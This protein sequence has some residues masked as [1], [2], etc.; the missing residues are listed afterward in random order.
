[1]NIKQL[2][3]GPQIFTNGKPKNMAEQA[4]MTWDE[5]EGLVIVQNHNLRRMI[6]GLILVIIVLSVGL[7]IQSLKSTVIPYIVEVDHVTGE[8]K[9]IGKVQEQNR[10]PKDIEIKY[11]LRRFIINM[12]GIPLDPVA[13]KTQWQ[14]AYAFLTKNAAAK[15]TSQ[16]QSEDIASLFGKKT[17][18][19][20]II[21]VLPMEGG[22]SYQVR[23]NEEEFAIGSGQKTTVPMSGVFTVTTIPPKD[24][25]TS[26]VNPFGIYFSDFNW[27]KD[28]S[29]VT[30]DIRVNQKK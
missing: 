15:M 14:T 2:F 16:V 9:N 28:A 11:F 29:I 17:V 24:E 1:M 12:R 19:V 3:Q 18:Q 21:S 4:K 6:V 22:N 20:N 26:A 5:R 10:A 8:V 25:E 13:F 27:T 7:V 30:Q 23:W